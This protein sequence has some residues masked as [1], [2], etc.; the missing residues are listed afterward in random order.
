MPEA[1]ETWNEDLFKLKLPRIYMIISEINRR[2]CDEAWAKYPGNWDKIS[3]MAII[4]YGQV[5]M[6]NLSVIGSHT[7][8]GVSA[9]HSDIL[10]TSC[11]K[12]LYKMYPEKFTNVTNGIAHRRWLCYSNPALASLLD[13]CIGDGYKKNPSEL[14]KFEKFA[15]DKNVLT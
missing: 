7:V 8:N 10:K 4:A 1:L 6:A 5:R 9:L 13:Q 2:F 3:S 14:R 12:D 15:D 11:F